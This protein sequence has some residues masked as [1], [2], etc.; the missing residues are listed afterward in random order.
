M[1]RG[2]GSRD[3]SNNR[4]SKGEGR[5]SRSSVPMTKERARAIQS[6]VDRKGGDKGFKSRA[7]RA[8]LKNEGGD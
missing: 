7:A 6:A 2:K 8:A 5:T 3:G 1:S 4:G